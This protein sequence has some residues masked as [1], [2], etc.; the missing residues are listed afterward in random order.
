MDWMN[1][2]YLAFN[3][4]TQIAC[5]QNKEIKWVDIPLLSTMPKIFCFINDI[6]KL[7]AAHGYI[8]IGKPCDRVSAKDIVETLA[9]FSTIEIKALHEAPITLPK[10]CKIDNAT[11]NED[12][13]EIKRV[14][15]TSFDTIKEIALA[16][17]Q[18]YRPNGRP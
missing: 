15:T 9:G 14:L 13:N 7:P 3:S 12:L 10:E 1:V 6:R 5:E 11:L 8:T 4:S 16:Q 2:C 18:G 17:T